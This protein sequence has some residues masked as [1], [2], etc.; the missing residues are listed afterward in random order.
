MCYN[1]NDAETHRKRIKLS[2]IPSYGDTN[3]ETIESSNS[4]IGWFIQ[5]DSYGK[6]DYSYGKTDLI[7]DSDN[8]IGDISMESDWE[9]HTLGERGIKIVKF[10]P[11]V[12]KMRGGTPPRIKN[13]GCNSLSVT[14][15]CTF[16]AG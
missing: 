15:L 1:V 7:G 2:F 5:N 4:D 3:L 13:A 6:N 8:L 14:C 16:G 11:V 12:E 9:L 10:P